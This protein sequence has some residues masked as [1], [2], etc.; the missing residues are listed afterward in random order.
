MSDRSV[1]EEQVAR[2]HL[3]QV[4]P[5]AQWAYLVGVLVGSTLVMLLLIVVLAGRA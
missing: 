3:A 5:A 4:R 2:E 1:D